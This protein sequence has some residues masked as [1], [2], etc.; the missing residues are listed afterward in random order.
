M[1]ALD[2]ELFLELINLAL[3]TNVDHKETKKE[4]LKIIVEN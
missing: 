3:K 2:F 1:I 4:F